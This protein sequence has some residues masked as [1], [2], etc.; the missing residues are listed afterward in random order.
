MTKYEVLLSKTAVRQL[1]RLPGDADRRIKA[2][3]RTLEEDPRRPRPGADIRLLSG[4][5]DPP[6]YRLRVGDY[7]ILFFVLTSE[8]RVTE[9]LHRSQA[10]RGID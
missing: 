9:I 10:Y 2:K 4:S 8:V 5:D 6:L 7:R 1:H 3:L